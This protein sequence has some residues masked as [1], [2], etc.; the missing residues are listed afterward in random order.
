MLP[1]KPPGESRIEPQ[2]YRTHVN[3]ANHPRS[4]PNKLKSRTKM[5]KQQTNQAQALENDSYKIF[6]S[7]KQSQ[8]ERWG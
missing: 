2:P 6:L 4:L 8:I 5:G 1:P 7:K 3:F